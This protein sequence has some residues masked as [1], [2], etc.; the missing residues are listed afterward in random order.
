MFR[1]G[2]AELIEKFDVT[3][4]PDGVESFTYD[5]VLEM[6]GEYDVLQSMF[7]FTVDKRLIDAGGERLKMIS[8]YAVGYDNIDIEYA[9]ER[10]IAVSN[11]PDPV[12]E[13]TADMAMGLLLSSTR[14][15]AEIDR[16]L[17]RGEVKVELLGNLGHSL[18]GATLGIIGMGRI[19]QAL[20]RRAVASG[21]KI[22]YHNRRQLDAET[23]A[24][25]G[26]KYL[27]MD[28]LLTTADVVSLNAPHTA[29]TRHIIGEV[30]LKMMKRS[31]ILIN[32][33]RGALVDERALVDA[34]RDGEIW[35]AGL[36]VF[37]FG[38]YPMEELLSL[39]NVVMSPHLGTQTH[40]VRN[41]M[42]AYVS[43]NIINFYE[44]GFVARVD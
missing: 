31:A 6:I 23:E 44:G 42:A 27:S 34:L 2:Y 11:T 5:E 15:I 1:E 40:E 24:R 25:Y 32:T 18:C 30:E 33:A 14:R 35:G 9:R 12:T 3:F 26:A 4:P 20:A 17:R 10:G 36:D 16:A 8:N 19:G 37:E 29:E 38:D 22:V 43:T 21:M 7:N 28:E 13:P 41:E 39:D